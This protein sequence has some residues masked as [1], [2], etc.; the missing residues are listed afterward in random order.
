MIAWVVS[1]VRKDVSIVDTLWGLFFLLALAIYQ[2]VSDAAG[3]RAT[4]V[5]VLVAIWALRLSLYIAIR[6]HGQPEDPRYR[7]MREKNDPGFSYKSIYLVFGLQAVLATIIALPLLAASGG[8]APLNLLD[9]IG[10]ALWLTGFFFEAVGDAQLARFKANP[11]NRG[12]VLDSGLWR[13][14]RHPNYFGEATLWWGYFFLAAAT[15]G[16]W[17]VISPL[18]M[19]FFLLK[20]SG[21]A[22][23]EKGLS[24]TKPQYADYVRRTNAFIPG[25]PRQTA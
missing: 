15:G 10:I 18:I 16:W 17:T 4:V 23:L 7:A 12:Q 21:V 6:N 2:H 9:Y 25:P 5:L 13:Y 22:L 11:A 19:T 3:P 1:L 20:V 8:N 14:T 24:E